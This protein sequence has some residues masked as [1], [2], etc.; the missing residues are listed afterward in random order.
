MR[1]NRDTKGGCKVKVWCRELYG[2]YFQADYIY[3]EFEADWTHGDGIPGCAFVC[4]TLPGD[5]EG[6]KIAGPF[7][8]RIDAQDWLDDYFRREIQGKDIMLIKGAVR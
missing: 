5:D 8:A 2:A 6:R 7:A 1:T 3:V 4:A